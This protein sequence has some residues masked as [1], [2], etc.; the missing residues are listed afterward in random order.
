MNDFICPI[1]GDT[2][3]IED[4]STF[5]CKKDR[6]SF[7]KID[8]IWRF[9]TPQQAEY[10]ENFIH[11]YET[12][13]QAEGRGSTDP[14]YFRALPFKDLTGTMPEMWRMRAA[15][16]RT[17][18]KHVVQPMRNAVLNVLDLGAGN[19]WL[20]NR[21]ALEGHKVDAVDL[22]TNTWD[23]LGAH[24]FYETRFRPVQA[25]YDALP[26]KKHR[27]DLVVFNA[28]F[29]YSED[30]D[31]TLSHVLHLLAKTGTLTIIDTPIYKREETGLLMVREREEAFKKKYGFPSNVLAMENFLTD[32]RMQRLAATYHLSMRMFSPKY[33]LSRLLLPLREQLRG[34]RE[35][36]RFPVIVLKRKQ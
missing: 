6:L 25:A 24:V 7:R 31:T 4:E 3:N 22:L 35:P 8:G 34:R 14:A 5:F 2:P 28:S 11:D 33:G 18:M 13:R 9:L 30:Y 23:G 16:F 36:A 19:C 32:A 20:S 29:H 10:Y 12:I 17:F 21:L 26:F 1:C 15:G 27:Y